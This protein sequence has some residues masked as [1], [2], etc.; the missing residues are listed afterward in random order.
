[1][2]LRDR[3]EAVE[4]DITLLSVDAI[5][6]AANAELIPGLGVDGAIRHAAGPQI[7]E[8]LR[9]IGG[10]APGSAVITPGYNLPAQYAIHT[11]API[12]AGT[13]KAHEQN[14]VFGRCY[15]SALD[16]ADANNIRTIAFPAIGTGAYRWPAGL[17][18]KIALDIVAAHLRQCPQQ[19][20]V[21]F[22]CFVRADRERYEGLIARLSE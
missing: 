12:W 4:G 11:V 10:C 20:R 15:Q 19:T 6:N 13:A 3:I 5:V 1:M 9:L 7:D 8:D 21:M 18:A 17:A 14:A 16:L 2:R 22:C